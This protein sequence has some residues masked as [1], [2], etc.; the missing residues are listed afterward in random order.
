[1]SFVVCFRWIAFLAVAGILL[2]PPTARVSA[3]ENPPF[4]PDG[5]YVPTSLPGQ[6]PGIPT[7][8]EVL[9]F[10]LGERPVRYHEAVNYL[11]T[12]AERSPRVKL[13]ECGHTHEGRALYYALISSEENLSRLEEIRGVAA[14]LAD[15]RKGGATAANALIPNQPLIAWLMYSIHGDELSGVD[16]SLQVA[17]QLA[18][19]EDSLTQKL[20]RELLVGIDPIENPDGRERY[21]AQMQQWR[22]EVTSTDMQSIQHGGVWP[23]GRTNHYLFDLNRDWFILSQPESRARVKAIRE[24]NPQLVVD[25]HEMG[26]DDTYLFS[27]SREPFNPN[28]SAVT[29]NWIKVFARDQA[30]AFDRYGWNYYTRE[31]LEEWYPGYGSS[32]PLLRGAVSILYEQAGTDG[33]PLRRPDGTLL[34]FREAVHHHFVSS[35]SNLSTAADNRQA[36]LRDYLQLH[37]KFLS[38]TTA[39]AAFLIPARENPSLV[40]RLVERLLWQGVE[41]EVIEE[42]TRITGLHSYWSATPETQTLP[43][44]TYIIKTAQPLRPLIEAALE[45]DTRMT[46]SFLRSERESLE[47]GKGTRLYEVSAWSMPLAY[48]IEAYTVDRLPSLRTRAIQETPAPNG[49]VTGGP[50]RYGYLIDYQDDSGVSALV[51]LLEGGYT[52]RSAREPFMIEDRSYQR[53]TLLLRVVENPASL[54]ADL[55]EICRTTGAVARGVNTAFSQKG[56]DLGG[57]DFPLLRS[58]RIALLAGPGISSNHAGSLWYL[59]DHELH[60]RCSIINST[61]FGNVDLRP[62]NVLVLP[63]SGDKPEDFDRIIGKDDLKKLKEWVSAG[64]TL[65]AM[66]NAAAFLADSS[67]DFSQVRLRRQSL[68]NLEQFEAAARLEQSIGRAAIDSVAFY[69]GRSAAQSMAP[70][71]D[72]KDSTEEMEKLTALDER[73]RLFMPRGAI[74]NVQLNDEHWMNFGVGKRIPAIFYSDFAYLAKKPVQITGRF[75]EGGNLRLAGLLWPEARD[76]WAGS[77]YAARESIGNGQLILFAGQPNFRS[78]FYGTGRMLINSIFLGPGWGTNQPNPW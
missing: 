68:K 70:A 64:G 54:A 38:S 47:K 44:G 13:V 45:F 37:R 40:N 21:L 5:V 25:A 6:A 46:T 29:E 17:Y 41:I 23:W 42:D 8:D 57:N 35:I 20:R 63:T 14:Q 67:R 33:S 30:Q 69:E 60:S 12:L 66:E 18:A 26:G 9:G 59:L 11:R 34:T 19:G 16:A 7:P 76:R 10:P 4:F 48:G 43:R 53:G 24:W 3:Q 15:P 1:M 27:P 73:Q 39:P 52:V 74:L 56:P 71:G 78:Y 51:R 31:W 75:A 62:Y 28:I 61:S 36:I 55:S 77:V 22:G 2:L 49:S 65:I 58:P 50:A 72:K 32:W